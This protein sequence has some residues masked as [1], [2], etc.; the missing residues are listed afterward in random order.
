MISSITGMDPAEYIAKIDTPKS[1]EKLFRFR[2]ETFVMLISGI[3]TISSK[4]IANTKAITAQLD[5][6]DIT[7]IPY[8][9][10][11]RE[12]ITNKRPRND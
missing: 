5:T 4:I 9:M 12:K 7:L 10:I 8:F 6:F 3:A 11:K 2:V 1:T